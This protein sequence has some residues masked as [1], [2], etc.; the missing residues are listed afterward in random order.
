MLGGLHAKQKE[1]QAIVKVNLFKGKK[2][3][4]ARDGGEREVKIKKGIG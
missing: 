2:R 3:T 1:R 4:I